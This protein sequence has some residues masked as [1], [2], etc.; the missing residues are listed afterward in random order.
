MLVIDLIDKVRSFI[1]DEDSLNYRYTDN[2][3]R[4]TKIPVGIDLFNLKMDRQ[5]EITGTGDS[6]EISLEPTASEIPLICLYTVKGILDGEIQQNAH[7][8]VVITDP[9]GRSDLTKISAELREQRDRIQE[10]IKEEESKARISGAIL[11]SEV[12]EDAF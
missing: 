4:D 7:K 10:Q 3:L 8:A 2:V 1:G 11:D 9:A 12:S 6:A 5:F